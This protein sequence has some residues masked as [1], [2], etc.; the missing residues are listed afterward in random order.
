MEPENSFMRSILARLTPFHPILTDSPSPCL[1]PP[2]HFVIYLFQDRHHKKSRTLNSAFI[3]WILNNIMSIYGQ[4][5]KSLISSPPQIFFKSISC[6]IFL[7]N[8]CVYYAFS[9]PFMR[10]NIEFPLID[11][12]DF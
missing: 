8:I 12:D 4:R 3:L 2:F 5:D 11:Q 9:F 7:L 10:T 6:F 1:R